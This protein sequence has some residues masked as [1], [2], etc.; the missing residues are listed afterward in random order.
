MSRLRDENV[1]ERFAQEA[2]RQAL[3]NL[4]AVE[5][6]AGQ[7]PVV[8]AP[9]WPGILLHEAVGHGLEG[10]FNRK[11]SSAFS[12]RIGERVAAPGVTVVDDATLA[13]Q[14]GRASCRERVEGWAAA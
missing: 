8:L 14:I 9:G 12:G 6:P 4:E 2:V 7:M 13:D 3:V 5:A 1:A 10:D 11:G